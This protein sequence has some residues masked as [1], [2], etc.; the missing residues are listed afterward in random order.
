MKTS[1]ILKSFT[2]AIALGSASLFSGGCSHSGLEY[3]F[4]APPAYSS[5]ENNQRVLRNAANDW[6]QAVED[7]DR[8]VTMTRPAGTLTSWH[9][10]SSD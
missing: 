9:I 10:S 4:L 5:T 3:D 1:S 2:L 7:F 6:S 8:T